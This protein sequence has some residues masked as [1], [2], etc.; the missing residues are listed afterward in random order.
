M[1]ADIHTWKQEEG[2]KLVLKTDKQRV[3]AAFLFRQVYHS[4]QELCAACPSRIFV[5][6]REHASLDVGVAIF[7]RVRAFHCGTF[8]FENC[9]R[10]ACQRKPCVPNNFKI[11]LYS[12]AGLCAARYQPLRINQGL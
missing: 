12:R 1:H 2:D 6:S 7:I 4:C 9:N 8:V 3:L 10:V 5:C 11:L